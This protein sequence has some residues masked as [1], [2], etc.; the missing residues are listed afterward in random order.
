MRDEEQRGR[1]RQLTDSLLVS[2]TVDECWSYHD[3]VQPAERVC[4]Q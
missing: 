4:M 1:R 2:D 3:I